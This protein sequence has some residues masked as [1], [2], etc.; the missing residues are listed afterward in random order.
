MS[1]G[2]G[3][4]LHPN[5]PKP[6]FGVNPRSIKGTYWWDKTRKEVYATGVCAACE[7]P[8]AKIYK[9]RL[10][11]HECYEVDYAQGIARV[12]DIVALCPSCHSFIHSGRLTTLLAR[13]QTKPARYWDVLYRGLMLLK[14]GGYPPNPFALAAAREGRNHCGEGEIPK[15]ATVEFLEPA[16][17]K[18]PAP[19]SEVAWDNWRLEFEGQLYAPIRSQAEYMEWV[20]AQHSD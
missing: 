8:K 16:I 5:I 18:N 19:T 17:A 1:R 11:A 9:N 3:L 4:L 2:V 13:G 20:L 12:A 15:W 10:E 6:L 14:H 7:T